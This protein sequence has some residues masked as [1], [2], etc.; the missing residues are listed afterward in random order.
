MLYDFTASKGWIKKKVIS[1]IMASKS[2]EE[3][4]FLIKTIFS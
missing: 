3:N 2:L 4:V 1:E